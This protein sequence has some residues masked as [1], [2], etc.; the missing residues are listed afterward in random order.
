MV[1]FVVFRPSGFSH[2]TLPTPGTYFQ[3]E[4]ALEAHAAVMRL[5]AFNPKSITV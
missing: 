2:L 4:K 3:A 5:E 1:I